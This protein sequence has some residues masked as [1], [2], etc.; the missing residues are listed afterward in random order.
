MLYVSKLRAMD[1]HRTI[2]VVERHASHAAVAELRDVHRA[3]VIV[4]DVTNDSVLHRLR[5]D[6][7]RRALFLTGDDFVNLD[8]AAKVLQLAPGMAGR[9]VVHVSDLGFMKAAAGSSVARACELFNG[10]EFAAVHLVQQHLLARFYSTPDSDFVVLAGF[11]RFGQTVLHQLQE[12]ARGSFGNV[13]I[14]DEHATRNARAFQERP[15]FDDD[16]RH[17]ILDGDLLDPDVWRRVG[18]EIGETGQAP[19]VILGSG[20]DGTNL[21]AA[22]LARK[23]H[24]AAYLIV[25]SFGASPFTEE[26][27]A[28]THLEAFNL[29]GLIQDG[30]P[31]S[32]F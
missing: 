15:G 6:R 21:H 16:Y 3:I 25:R 11:G 32:W 29:A 13:L 4:G 8:A 24:P 17:T 22:L 31:V 23:H 10:H 27:A 30:M 19:V 14:V 12:H 1:P 28:D 9:V 20:N 18:E 7:C 2:V 26:I 5:M